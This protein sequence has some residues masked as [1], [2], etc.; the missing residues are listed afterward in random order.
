MTQTHDKLAE[1]GCFSRERRKK[2]KKH[3]S[4]GGKMLSSTVIYKKGIYLLLFCR[5]A[6]TRDYS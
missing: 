2:A 4:K 5:V 6:P 3:C 1:K